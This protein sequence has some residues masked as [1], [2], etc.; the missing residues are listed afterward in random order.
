MLMKFQGKFWEFQKDFYTY[1]FFKYTF[2]D[3]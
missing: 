1:N 3:T 2:L